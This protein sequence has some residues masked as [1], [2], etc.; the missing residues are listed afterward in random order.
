LNE[1]RKSPEIIDF[2]TI[3][4]TYNSSGKS[5][6]VQFVTETYGIRYD[7]AIK[8][9]R[10]ESEYL[11]NQ[12]RDRYVLKSETAS[13]FLSLEELETGNKLDLP[14]NQ[15]IDINEIVVK[16]I[17]DKFFEMSKYITLE[18]NSKKIIFN[19][20]AAQNDGYQIEYVNNQGVICNY[21]F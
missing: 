3:V 10:R 4:D 13:P 5:A 6:A 11:Y 18:Q 2:K 12:R 20:A 14:K 19:M 15:T 8:R 1:R 21:Q 17:K 16:L 9:L 7:T